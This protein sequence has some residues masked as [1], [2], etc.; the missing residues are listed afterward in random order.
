[1]MADIAKLDITGRHHRL[2]MICTS[3]TRLG[4]KVGELEMK[5][6]L[7]P[8]DQLATKRLRELNQ[9]FNCLHFAVVDLLKQQED[10]EMV[11]SAFDDHEDTVG[12]L[13]DR[14]QLVLQDE[15][16]WKA[17]TDPQQRGLHRHL[18]FIEIE[19][20]DV[21]KAVEALKPG[22]ELDCCLFE[23]QEEQISSLKNELADVSHN[24]ATLDKDETGLEDRRSAISKAIF[25]TR[26]QIRWLL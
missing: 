10:L 25:N 20:C 4:D 9:D 1:M 8:M 19:L 23:Q 2:G 21:S 13:G 11:Q 24:I 6:R 7:S 26:L 22:P 17:P 14:L 5:E 18:T 16:V 15:P 12:I 3:I